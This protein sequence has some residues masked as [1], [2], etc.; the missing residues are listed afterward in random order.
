MSEKNILELDLPKEIDRM[1]TQPLRFGDDWAGMFVRGDD[2]FKM[3]LNMRKASQ[4]LKEKD[5][6]L[7]AMLKGQADTLEQ[8][9]EKGI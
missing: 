1:E 3:V 6:L 9:I 4:E 8:C 7:S 5:P 2:A